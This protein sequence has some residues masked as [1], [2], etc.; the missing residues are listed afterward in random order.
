MD[1]IITKQAAKVV[2][3][4]GNAHV[5]INGKEIPVTE[6]SEL[7]SG[8]ELILPPGAGALLQLE[9]G[10][11]IPVGEMES[12]LASTDEFTV[13]DEIAALQ[14]LL[15]NEDFDPTQELEAT[16][17]G[18]SSPTNTGA[19]TSAVE[20]R[21]GN[22]TVAQA[23]FDTEAT[24]RSF[25][26]ARGLSQEFSAAAN[27]LPTLTVSGGG[28]VNEGSNVTFNVELGN[29][30]NGDVT[31]T[32]VLNNGTTDNNDFALNPDGTLTVEINGENVSFTLIDGKLTG[33]VDLGGN[34]TSFNV[35][36][37]TFNDSG[38]PV[39]EGDESF[40]LDISASLGSQTLTDSGRATISD[41]GVVTDEPGE[42]LTPGGDDDRPE[43]ASVTDTTVS[44]GD[45]TTFT[46]TLTNDSTTNTTV[47]LTLAGDSADKNVDF[48][49]TTVTVN[50]TEISV[51]ADGSFTVAVAAGDT[52]FNVVV[53]T[54]TDD[55]YE[56]D[57]TFTV[58]AKTD[59]Q[60]SA[61]IGTATITD[62]GHGGD[63]DRPEVA[64]VTDTTVSEG[65]DATF[66]VTLTNDSTT[67]TEVT[68]TLAGDSADKNVDF[69]GTTVTVNGTEI[70]VAA[71]GSFTVAVAAGD[72]AFNVVVNTTTDDTYEGDETFTVS[73]KT[74]NQ[75]SAVIG[76]ATITDGGQGGGDDDRP[77]V[78]S[79]SDT[80]V[81]EG[82]D[83]TFTVTLTND[84]TTNT[85]V[86]LTLAG[87]SADKN[88]DFTGT[89]VTVNGTE[90]SVAADGSFTVAVAAGDT[91]FNVVVNTTTDDTYEG[92]ETFTVSAKTDNQASAA[93]GTATITDGGNDGTPD[94]GD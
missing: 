36:I 12:N 28:E 79:V 69:T 56:G 9:D 50:G 29:P 88:V 55:T 52:A 73:A 78:A 54:T 51:A 26:N 93:V 42:D 5:K 11:F 15:L 48:T 33:T 64:S 37:P 61:V 75:A 45:A 32:L 80:T 35:V 46:V 34:V 38:S 66:T 6:L 17:A 86:T 20:S 1:S 90:I 94:G 23:G 13:D 30:V 77:E 74:D 58:S 81:S 53:N 10:S 19:Q 14:E 41:D 57:E 70:S 31:Y 2:S 83:A 24:A 65:D 84:S 3:V 87:D 25:A 67:N 91:A 63:D 62:G 59:N 21:T 18:N 72:T 16:A 71:D 85:E 89:T 60:A 27:D 8:T 4:N 44:E 68:L 49:G 40:S 7:T 92:D 47:S 43:V 76:T 22:E 82:D 39:F